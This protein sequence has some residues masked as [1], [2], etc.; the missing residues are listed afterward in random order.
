MFV[1]CAIFNSK[2][3]QQLP[4]DQRNLEYQNKKIEIKTQTKYFHIMTYIS[5]RTKL[6][7][8][9]QHFQ[10][11]ICLLGVMTQS[12]CVRIVIEKK[13]EHIFI[14]FLKITFILVNKRT[15][16]C[17]LLQCGH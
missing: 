15:I 3:F 11:R 12:Y 9:I 6:S 2:L 7:F 1:A 5:I 10:V 17:I 4:N 14:L 16:L 8:L 13:S